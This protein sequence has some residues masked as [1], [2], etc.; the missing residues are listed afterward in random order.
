MQVLEIIINLLKG[1]AKAMFF[2]LSVKSL[3]TQRLPH[4]L[5][6]VI[7]LEPLCC[8]YALTFAFLR[9]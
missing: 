6:T 7:L 2:L 1:K 3:F 4:K 9:H 8:A 5:F